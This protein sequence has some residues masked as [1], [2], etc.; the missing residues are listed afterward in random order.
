[1]KKLEYTYMLYTKDCERLL[2]ELEAIGFDTSFH[3]GI[4]E[5][6]ETAERGMNNKLF[7]IIRRAR[8]T[9]HKDVKRV[10]GQKRFPLAT[11]RLSEMVQRVEK[12]KQI[13]IDKSK[14]A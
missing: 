13:A 7:E 2:P 9:L 8:K 14:L 10:T 3:R 11:L 1:M 12:I 6:K 5:L 4:I